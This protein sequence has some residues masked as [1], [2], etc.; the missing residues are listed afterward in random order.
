MEGAP[1][2]HEAT[3]EGIP[4]VQEITDYGRDHL[5]LVNPVLIKQGHF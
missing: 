2:V 5:H 3:T 4:L 1:S